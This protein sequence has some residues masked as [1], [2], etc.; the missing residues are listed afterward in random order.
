MFN[1]P[2]KTSGA[3]SLAD[4]AGNNTP[5]QRQPQY[6][7]TQ[8]RPQHTP[9]QQRQSASRNFGKPGVPLKKGQ[10]FGLADNGAP[11]ISLRV[12]LDWDIGP[13]PMDLDASVFMLGTNGKV[14]GDE[15]F[16]YYYALT[17]PDGAIRHHG[18]NPDG[19]GNDDEIIDFNLPM[20]D[21]RVQRM[22][23]VVTINEALERS[24]NFSMVKSAMLRIVNQ[25]TQCEIARYTLADYGPVTSMI[26]GEVY[27][28]NGQW[29]FNPVGDGVTKDLN[30]ICDMYGVNVS[31]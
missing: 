11:L 15:W 22:V 17:S 1:V 12:C 21:N 20:V 16:V 4:M 7:S 24:L 25:S 31:D 23:V 13:T 8:Q 2:M 18:D 27:R 9:Q 26:I 19:R 28:H 14:L 30:G 5:P 10:K 3:M 6:S 29:K